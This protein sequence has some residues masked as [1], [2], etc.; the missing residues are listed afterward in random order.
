MSFLKICLTLTYLHT[1][2]TLYDHAIWRRKIPSL[3]TRSK[4]CDLQLCYH[5]IA[6]LITAGQHAKTLLTLSPIRL[7]SS[8]KFRRSLPDLPRPSP[9][10]KN[11]K[12]FGIFTFVVCGNKSTQEGR[13]LWLGKYRAIFVRYNILFLLVYHPSKIEM[14]FI[15]S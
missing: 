11:Q 15:L 1:F 7:P 4:V 10:K 5:H 2:A 13:E 9:N 3:S 6:L 12:Y 14:V 8:N